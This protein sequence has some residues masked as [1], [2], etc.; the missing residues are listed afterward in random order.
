MDKFTGRSA[1]IPANPLNWI[2]KNNYMKKVF[3]FM[4]GCALLGSHVAGYSQAK[5]TKAQ[6]EAADKAAAKA[7]EKADKAAAKAKEK[8]DKE[9]AKKAAA[10]KQAADKVAAT[11]AAEAK[12][13]ADKAA[14][15]AKEKAD[16]AAAKAKTVTAPT[17]TAPAVKP[18]PAPAPT[19][20][21][22]VQ[23]VN[24]SADKA[25]GT[26]DKGRTIYEG[27]RGG[28]YRLSKNGNK[29]YIKKN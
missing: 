14:A 10:D 12:D 5:L 26:D 20:K 19:V 13:K 3:A 18:A 1:I 17:V 6:Q 23:P 29:E 27:P 24:P 9:V 25:V 22:T 15:K 28:R 11:K 16:K 7:K 4:I 8:A 2:N 21:P